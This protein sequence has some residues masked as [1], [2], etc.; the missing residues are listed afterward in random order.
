MKKNKKFDAVLSM[1]EIRQ[2]LSEKYWKNPDILKTEMKEIKE[3]YNLNPGSS[4]T[5]KDA[6]IQ[7]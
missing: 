6:I 7:H 2:N 1:R 5:K 3:K 4:V